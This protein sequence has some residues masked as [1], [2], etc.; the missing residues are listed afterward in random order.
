LQVPGP[1]ELA[2]GA[3]ELESVNPPSSNVALT[4][5]VVQPQSGDT[6]LVAPGDSAHLPPSK[7]DDDDDVADQLSK[8]PSSVLVATKLLIGSWVS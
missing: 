1:T 6:Q 3:K 2:D 4:D 5:Q 8:Y 7:E